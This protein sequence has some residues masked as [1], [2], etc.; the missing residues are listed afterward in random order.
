VAELHVGTDRVRRAKGTLAAPVAAVPDPATGW[1]ELQ[2]SLGNQAVCRLVEASRGQPR[3]VQREVEAGKLNV[4]G[5]THP[6]LDDEEERRDAEKKALV[7][8]GL[9]EE[10]QYW[11]EDEFTYGQ[12]EALGDSPELRALQSAVGLYRNLDIAQKT[13]DVAKDAVEDEDVAD[14]RTELEALVDELDGFGGKDGEAARFLRELRTVLKVQPDP[15]RLDDAIADLNELAK[16]A[17]SETLKFDG[18]ATRA[19]ALITAYELAEHQSTTAQAKTRE[20]ADQDT[21]ALVT[22]VEK[23]I[24]AAQKALDLALK[25]ADSDYD[26]N[27]LGALDKKL[28]TRRSD[29]MHK[30]AEQAADEKKTGVWKVGQ[31]HVDDLEKEDKRSYTLTTE[32]KFNTDFFPKTDGERPG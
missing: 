23:S 14:P 9:I 26:I 27:E 11:T 6:D 3:S 21:A 7:G 22:D 30:A 32:A 5:E 15:D 16:A 2:R 28:T 19:D 10:G 13:L 31:R 18:F 12:D 20:Q 1:L 25:G 29:Q 24:A 8:R 4:V 17:L